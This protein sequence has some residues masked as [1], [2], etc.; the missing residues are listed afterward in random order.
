MSR[1]FLSHSSR[2]NA[3]AI[4]LRD[5]LAA[6]GWAQDDIFLDVSASSGIAPGERW[7]KALT[8]AAGRCEVVVFLISLDWLSSRWCHEELALAHKLNKRMF[9]VL[10]DS[11]SIEDVPARLRDEW[12]FE[13]DPP[14]ETVWRLG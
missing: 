2:N 7:Q 4:A 11:V 8:D 12:Q 1:I 6:N 13:V 14:G 10:I 9:G 3:Q 5:W